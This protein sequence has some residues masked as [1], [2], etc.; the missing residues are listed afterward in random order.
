LY[1]AAISPARDDDASYIAWGHS[2]LTSPWGNVIATT[3]E[4]ESIVYGDLDL[5]YVNEVREQ[6]PIRKQQRK[7][8]YGIS[9]SEF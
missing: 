7:D 9:H 6:I 5:S 8:L 2:T 4:K 3:D 1:V